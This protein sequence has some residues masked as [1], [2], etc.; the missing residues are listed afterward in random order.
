VVGEAYGVSSPLPYCL[1]VAA[2]HRGHP[3]QQVEANIKNLGF[4][5]QDTQAFRFNTPSASLEVSKNIQ[6]VQFFSIKHP[7]CFARRSFPLPF[8]EASSAFTA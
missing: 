2:I 7:G 1:S 4:K 5:L 6:A 8:I 3:T